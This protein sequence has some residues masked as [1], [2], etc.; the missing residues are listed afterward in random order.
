MQESLP[1]PDS[2]IYKQ[3]SFKELHIAREVF[4]CKVFRSTSDRSA[5]GCKIMYLNVVELR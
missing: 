4:L 1:K 5:T 2:A 3:V